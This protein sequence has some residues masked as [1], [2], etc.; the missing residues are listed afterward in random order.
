MTE[1]RQKDRALLD[2][3]RMADTVRGYMKRHGS[4]PKAATAELCDLIAVYVAGKPEG[5]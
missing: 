5:A 2:I 1:R 4:P 3:I